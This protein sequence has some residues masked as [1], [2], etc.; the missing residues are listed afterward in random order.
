M[1][2]MASI[3]KDEVEYV[4]FVAGWLVNSLGEI[5]VKNEITK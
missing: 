5:V 1:D 2:A 3:C 4:S